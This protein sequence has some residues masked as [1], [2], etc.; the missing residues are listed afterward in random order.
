M[1]LKISKF[2][3]L[4]NINQLETKPHTLEKLKETR[5][6]TGAKLNFVSETVISPRADNISKSSSSS[7]SC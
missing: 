1:N 2:Q 4:L 3:F 7:N 5:N 6:F